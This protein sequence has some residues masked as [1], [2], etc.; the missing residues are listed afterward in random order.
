MPYTNTSLAFLENYGEIFNIENDGRPQQLVIKTDIGM[1]FRFY[2]SG[3]IKNDLV[4]PTVMVKID[5]CGDEIISRINEN[6]NYDIHVN[7]VNWLSTVKIDILKIFSN[8]RYISCP[9]ESYSITQN[10]F[11]NTLLPT[12]KFTEMISIVPSANSSNLAIRTQDILI[13]SPEK[14]MFA[15]EARSASGKNASQNFTIHASYGI[16]WHIAMAKKIN[17]APILLTKIEP[18]IVEVE[19]PKEEATNSTEGSEGEQVEQ[20]VEEPI[21]IEEEAEVVDTTIEFLSPEFIDYN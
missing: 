9:T 12:K 14:I 5:F 4:M 7:G 18:W 6:Q 21:V 3:K 20:I 11:N 1:P 17:Q 2:L 16:E 13:D 8:S 15:V 19:F 10:R